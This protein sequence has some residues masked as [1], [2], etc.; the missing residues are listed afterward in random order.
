MATKRMFSIDIVGTDKFLCMPSTSQNLYFHLGLR[1]DDDGFVSSPTM[2][3]RLIGCQPDDL[4]VLISRGYVIRFESG[5]IVI[6]DWNLNNNKIKS[7][8]YRKTLY[9]DEFNLIE[10]Q[11]GRYII[12]NEVLETPILKDGSRMEPEWNRNGTGTEP[13]RNHNGTV[14][15]NRIDKNR[16]EEIREDKKRIDKINKKESCQQIVDMY[17]DICIS[18]PKVEKL[19]PQRISMI[20][21]RLK[22]YSEI[23]FQKLFEMAEASE[24][25]TGSSGWKAN[26]NWL[27]NETNMVKVLE[28][29]YINKKK[30]TGFNHQPTFDDKMDWLN[31]LD[32]ESDLKEYEY[33][34]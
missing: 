10:Q 8:R 25:L 2:T 20:S 4:E 30:D 7:D 23:E 24:F 3:M 6:T 17:N 34:G 21:S 33:E 22:E 15:K 26:F 29:N 9:Q 27:L 13:E 11:E 1:A 32:D 28:G 12:K 31:V 19:T 5:I 18:L 16:E 14:D